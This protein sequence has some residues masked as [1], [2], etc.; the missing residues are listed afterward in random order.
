MTGVVIPM[1]RLVGDDRHGTIHVLA[2]EGGG[3]EVGH[4]SASGDS[5]GDFSGPIEDAQ[6]AIARAFALNRDDHGGLCAVA[7]CDAARLQ[8]RTEPSIPFDRED[9]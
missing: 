1:R 6:D 9:F 5:W 7:I 2:L 8:R 4:E 3:F